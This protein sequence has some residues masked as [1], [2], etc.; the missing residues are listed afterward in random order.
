VCYICRLGG[1]RSIDVGTKYF[2][3]C[4]S[5]RKSGIGASFPIAA[6]RHRQPWFGLTH[7]VNSSL[8]STH[9]RSIRKGISAPTSNS[10]VDCPRFATIDV[11]YRPVMALTTIHA[12]PTIAAWIAPACLCL[13]VLSLASCSS[14]SHEVARVISPDSRNVAVLLYVRG[15][16]P[17]PARQE[18]YLSTADS[19]QSL[20]D[21]NLITRHCEPLNITWLDSQTL[22]VDYGTCS[23]DQFKNYWTSAAGERNKDPT[24]IDITLYR[25]SG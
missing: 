19:H 25:R 14:D 12:Q 15:A 17:G 1:R 2:T 6:L 13:I 20:R 18:L 21:P 16:A 9:A 3:C 23:I 4:A 10:S 24:R 5:G 22:Q 7:S 8:K 11:H